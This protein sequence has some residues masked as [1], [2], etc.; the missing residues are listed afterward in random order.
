VT[1]FIVAGQGDIRQRLNGDGL[2]ALGLAAP[3]LS[4]VWT[5]AVLPAAGL[6]L[7]GLRFTTTAQWYA[8]L[9]GMLV[10]ATNGRQLGLSG[11]DG[12]PAEPNAVACAVL[13]VHPQAR[14]RLERA[15]V[16]ALQAP[17]G[18]V[19]RSL[20]PVPSTILIRNLTVP[21]T[22]AQQL[23][24]AEPAMPAGEVSMY[25]ERGLII[26]PFAFAAAVAAVLANTPALSAPMPGGPAAGTPQ[27]F[28][29]I[30][31]GAFVHVIDPHGRPWTDPPNPPGGISFYTGQPGA[32]VQGARLADGLQHAWPTDA[33]AVL[34]GD[35][36]P[37]GV[38]TTPGRVR[39]GFSTVGT[40]NTAPLAWPPAGAR[41][42]VRDSL[43]VTA[44]D[45]TFHLLG[46]RTG[47]GREGVPGADNR[48]VQ[49]AAPQVRQG[50][51]VTLL[52]DGRSALGFFGA[53]L[54]GL[55]GG[56][57]NAG[58]T[59]GPIFAASVNYDDGAWPLPAAAGPAGAWPVSP[60]A[61]PVPG[62][63]AAVLNQLAPLRTGG[64]ARWITGSNDVVLTLPVGLPAGVVIRLYPIKVLLGTSPDEGPLLWRSDGPGAV[65]AAGATSLVFTDPFGLGPNPAHDNATLR[66]DAVVTW[67]SALGATPVVKLVANLAWP[68]GGEVA[69][70]PAL[71]ANPLTA[72]FWRGRARN[73]MLGAPS[74][75]TFTLGTVFQDPIKFVQDVV[76]QL[77]TDQNPRESPR[78]PT[79]SRT[80]S[81]LALQ[82]PPAVGG[83][84]LYRAVL[85]G[86]WLT[87]ECDSHTYRLGN[88]A[89]A[90][91]HEAH[92]PAVTA[93]SELGFDL[94][95]AAAH[96][97]RPVV[98]TADVAA[99]F[100]GG[101]NAGLPNNWVLLQANATSV[102]PNPPAAPTTI[103]GAVL[104][105]VPAYVETP[106]LALIPDDNVTDVTN[107]ITTQLG[108]WVTTPNDPELHR[109][110]V[111][112]V[113][114]CKYGRRDTQW[115]LRRALRHARDLVYIE[116]PLFGATSHP[117]G[118]PTDP[119]AAVDLITELANRLVAEPRLRVVILVP[120]NV[121]FVAGYEPW[122][123]YFYGAR[124]A[125]AQTLRTAGGTVN[126]PT[127]PRPRVV[128]AHPTGV[129]GRPLVIRTTTV[130]VDDVW[131]LTGTSTLSRRGLTFDGAT[132][133]VLADW[134]LDRGAGTAI[135]THRRSL[136]AAHLGVG[137][138]PVGGGAPPSPIGAPTGDWV[139]LHN[140]VSAHEAYA[141]ALM[142]G[143]GKLLSLWNGPNPAATIAHPPQIADPDGREGASTIVT[144]AAAIDSNLPT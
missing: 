63:D 13:R 142:H 21:F 44:V 133:M 138:T 130:I 9:P 43:R 83:A 47:T 97:A 2:A 119:L 40:L 135:R 37:D 55:Q 75:G 118:G 122:S 38:Q 77:S 7:P 91:Q 98:P 41:T 71:P 136:M 105:T 30:A 32:R 104:Q 36:D 59:S 99:P 15:F 49:E 14:L 128:I 25:D 100:T 81:L 127:G 103:A 121:P 53:V 57:P 90:G 111:R 27:Q 10:P 18:P 16:T 35:G 114:T 129:P 50:S 72:A 108:S 78:L 124:A 117:T 62:T 19:D 101:P 106:E 48:S 109:Q 56:N 141:D 64:S 89:A 5:P 28:G 23:A 93:T 88:P 96:R 12:T 61:T 115:A 34:S 17:G 76:R 112:E 134:T 107:W 6:N 82:L 131:C 60:P 69:R 116:T 3:L 33:T 95:V 80:E 39:F 51:P 26:D 79:M 20:R 4:P 94:W 87:A 11:L 22:L 67:V 92:A 113:R 84:D 68:V 140:P 123:A 66:A 65:L 29:N 86:G 58:F 102:P 125:A 24:A 110:L 143:Y 54:L 46:N 85:T 52:A 137:P 144:L 8:P 132:D 73:P 74:G 31:P 70:P 139:R 42:P 45:P 1:S 120:R 126:S